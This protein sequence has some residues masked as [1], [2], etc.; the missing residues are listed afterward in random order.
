MTAPPDPF[1]NYI[2]D[3]G[4]RTRRVFDQHNAASI[5]ANH[6]VRNG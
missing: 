4:P 3:W 6:A 2:T 5:G 1:T